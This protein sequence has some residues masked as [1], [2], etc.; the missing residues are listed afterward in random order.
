MIDANFN[1]VKEALRVAE[2]LSRFILKNKILAAAFKKCRHDVSVCLLTFPVSYVKLLL[3]RDSAHDV[4]KSSVIQ[5]TR[6]NPR[7]QDLMIANLKRAQEALRVLEEV[8]KIVSAG[9]AKQFQKIR[10][11]VYELEKR[12]ILKF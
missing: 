9:H 2:D 6:H 11:E 3:S 8:A 10:F 1:R 5:D 7:W 12:S 4:S